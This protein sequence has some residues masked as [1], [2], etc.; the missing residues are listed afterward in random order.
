[1]DFIQLIVGFVI[2]IYGADILIDGASSLAKNFNVPAIVIGLTVV[3]FGTSAPELAVN[4]F[5]SVEK[6]SD[7]VISNVLGSNI[8]NICLILGVTSVIKS[9]Q[10]NRNTTWLEI[11]FALLASLIVFFISSD[12]FL[13]HSDKDVISFSEG[14]ILLSFFVIFV[15]YNIELSISSNEVSEEDFQQMSLGKSILWIVLGLIGLVYGGDFI[16]TGAVSIAKSIGISD[17]IIGLTIVSIG[18]SLPELAAGI[19]AVRKGKIDIA[20]GN[21]VGSNIFNTFLVLGICALINP[22]KISSQIAFDI[23]INILMSVLLFV[24][25]VLENGERLSRSKGI[26]LLLAYIIY[27]IYTTSFA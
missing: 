18:T 17:R 19:T 10:V 27:I 6:K 24:F 25:I 16:V 15:V 14:L 2:L 8:A 5:S 11:P 9:L 7:L 23:S 13:D 4:I 12:V 20:I 22:I 21:V 1:M 26:L 3:A